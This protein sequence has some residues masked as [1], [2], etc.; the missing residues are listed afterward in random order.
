MKRVVRIDDSGRSAFWR[1]RI[2][3]RLQAF[4]QLFVAAFGEVAFFFVA[5]VMLFATVIDIV[6][7]V[8]GPATSRTAPVAIK[9]GEEFPTFVFAHG[10]APFA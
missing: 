4:Q 8:I 6:D 3:L 7:G 5:F 9:A 1:A 2:D 10:T